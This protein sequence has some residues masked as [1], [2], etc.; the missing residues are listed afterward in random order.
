SA[1]MLA[2]DE[3]SPPDHVAKRLRSYLSSAHAA[4]PETGCA[5]PTLGPEIARAG[6][7]VRETVEKSLKHTRQSWSRR[8]E[9]PGAAWAPIAQC[10]GARVL[11]RSVQSE[12]TRKEI[13]A[14]CRRHIGR[15]QA[16]ELD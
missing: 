6:P 13:L 10:A 7:K 4:N 11:A 12:K 15:T 8:L 5:L 2:G 16:L 9:D 3:D 14:A 1:Q